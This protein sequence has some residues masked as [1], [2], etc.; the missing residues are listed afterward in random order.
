LLET[1]SSS[2]ELIELT[3]DIVSA[4]VS[5]N[6]VA[7]AD[8]PDLIDQTLTALSQAASRGSQPHKAELDPAVSIKK[9]VTPDVITCLECGKL[10]KS[11]KR[12]IRTDHTLTPEE[13]REKW[14]LPYDYPMVAPNYAA[15]RSEMAK[16][17]GLGRKR[18]A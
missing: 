18:S 2:T 15:R 12:H 6:S 16:K 10:F 11:L 9:S 7:A 8:I 17:I 5:N 14:D 4:Y 1:E 13:Y 3:T